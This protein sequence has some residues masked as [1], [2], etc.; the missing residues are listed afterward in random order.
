VDQTKA[1]TYKIIKEPGNQD[2]CILQFKI[3]P[4]YEDLAFRIVN[5][6]W[7]YSHKKGFKSTFDRGVLQLH[8][9]FKY[10]SL[11]CSSMSRFRRL[12]LSFSSLNR[13]TFYRK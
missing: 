11:I 13:R 8:F 5:K 3:G 6:E 10:A 7:E 2:T 1:P 9:N 4:P 12:T